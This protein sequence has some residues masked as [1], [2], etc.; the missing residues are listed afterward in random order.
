MKLSLILLSFALHVSAA[1]FGQTISLKEENVS[2]PDLFK[3]IENRSPYR[4][5]FASDVLPKKYFASIYAENATISH[6][7]EKILAGANLSWKQLQGNRIVI[8]ENAADSGTASIIKTITGI[9]RDNT[10]APLE[11]VSVMIKATGTGVTTTESGRF[12]INADEGDVLVFSRVGYKDQEITIT[13]QETLDVILQTTEGSLDEVIVVGYGVQKK[14]SL[15]GALQTIDGG[16][17]R[18]IT[19]PSVENMLNAKVAGAFVAPGSGRPGSR[20]AVVIRGQATL[21]GT[22]SPLWVIDGV[23]VGSS[24]GDLNPDDIETMTVLKDAAST[25]IYGSQGANGVVVVTTKKARAGKT[26]INVS[27]RTG[28]NQLTNGNL[29]MMNGAELYDYYAS[30]ANANTIAFPRWNPNLR[31]SNFDWWDLATQNGFTQNHNASISSGTEKLQSYFS[32]GLYDEKGAVK[33]YDYRRYNLRLTQTYQPVK[34]L[35]IKPAIVGSYRQVDDR[36]YSTTAM[37]SNFPWD[38]PYDSVGNLVPHRSSTWVNSAGTNYLYDLQWN[39]AENKNYELMG[40]L[41]FEV[42]IN[43][44]LTFNSVNSYRYNTYAASGYNDPRSNA[45]LNVNG[46]L[47]DYRSEYARRYTNQMLTVNRTWGKHALYAVGGYEFNDYYAKTLDVYGT[48]FIPGFQVLDVVAKPERT[49]GDI[50]EWAVQSFISKANYTYA[51]R[52]LLEASLRRDGASNFGDNAKYGNFFSISGGWNINKEAWFNVAWIDILKLRASY[53]SAG[54][55]PSALYPQYDLYSVSAAASYDEQ[56]GALISQIGNKDL[57][58]ERT[59]TTG[60]GVD[61][62]FFQNRGRIT[63]DYYNKNTDNILYRVPIS[64]L[65]GVTSIWQNIG[66][67][68]NKGIELSIGGDIIRNNDWLWSLDLNFGHNTNKLTKLY[69]TKNADGTYSVKPVIISDGLGIAGSAQRV[70]E[71]GRPV[72]TYYLKEWA[73]VNPNNGAPLWYRVE[74]DANGNE[75]SRDTVS[76]Y[77]QATFE[78]LGKASPKFFGGFTT[79]LQFRQFDLNSVFGYSIGG[80]V[81][82]YSRQEYDSD[83]TYTD[84]NQMKLMPEWSRWEKPGDIATHPVARYNNSQQGNQV[85]SR[86]LESNDFLRL[87]TL[88]LG[89]NFKLDKPAI[90][91]LRLFF[92]GENLLVITKYSGVDPEIPANDG[93]VLSSTSPSVYPATR[94]Y[95][96]GLNVSF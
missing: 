87:R 67:M 32:I 86:Y 25:A 58:W 59:Y 36:E 33:G 19:N 91:N 90:K 61:A 15:T 73:G 88:T 45:G 17:L 16:K 14:E 64:G 42:K 31:N 1:N 95:M 30:F 65:T 46:R 6:V 20:G 47:T 66:E 49:K 82:N 40:N 80:K 72:D 57:T 63:L 8:M 92:T 18:D 70:L 76:R 4:F 75:I 7:M 41:D 3:K 53:G 12:S 2:L 43:N 10:G 94:K 89:Y 77:A 84:R 51:G 71:P 22:T 37:Y 24:A 62:S 21:N 74:R 11:N 52:Y 68:N 26:T 39:H 81:Y 48:G 56:S 79:T 35:K 93:A 44:W 54:N 13:I 9:V 34:W 29:K 69:P 78:K 85:S 50:N 5:Y 55:R 23:I 60:I 83:G 38:S 96:F 27:S 28:V